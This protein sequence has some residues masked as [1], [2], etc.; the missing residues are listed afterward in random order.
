MQL[1]YARIDSPL[2]ISR[3]I[4]IYR[5][6]KTPKLKNRVKTS[7]KRVLEFIY[8][9]EGN[10]SCDP[11]FSY[12]YFRSHKKGPAGYEENEGPIVYVQGNR[13]KHVGKGGHIAQGSRE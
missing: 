10:P 8:V 11:L 13:F 4:F 9:F 3:K 2:S 6:F 7:C 1:T 5:H 12:E